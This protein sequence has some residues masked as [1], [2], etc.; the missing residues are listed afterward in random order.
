MAGRDRCASPAPPPYEPASG[1]FL[2]KRTKKLSSMRAILIHP[3]A[4]DPRIK[5]I[6]TVIIPKQIRL[7][8]FGSR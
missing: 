1:S 8:S 6:D 7:L 2:K 5:L 3:I 4:L